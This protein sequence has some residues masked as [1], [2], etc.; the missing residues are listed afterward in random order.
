MVIVINDFGSPASRNDFRLERLSNI[1]FYQSKIPYLN[2]RRNFP[3]L[4][5]PKLS[6]PSYHYNDAAPNISYSD[7]VVDPT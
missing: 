1:V 3:V 5:I 2:G 6:T 4:Q 7:R